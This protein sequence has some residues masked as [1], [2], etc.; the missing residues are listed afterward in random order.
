[1]KLGENGVAFFVEKA[2]DDDVPEYLATSPI[3]GS[4]SEEDVDEVCIYLFQTKTKL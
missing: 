1:M 2:E 3:P 4:R